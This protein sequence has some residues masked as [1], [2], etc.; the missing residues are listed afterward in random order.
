MVPSNV[1]STMVVPTSN[2]GGTAST[3][4]SEDVILFGSNF[5]A[6]G[7]YKYPSH[8]WLKNT[9]E[10]NKKGKENSILIVCELLSKF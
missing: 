9:I 8:P 10:R 7:A 1:R 4:K 5:E 2:D 3:P 6:I